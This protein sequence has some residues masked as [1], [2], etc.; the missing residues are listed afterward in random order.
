MA[1]KYYVEKKYILACLHPMPS[2]ERNLRPDVFAKSL[3]SVMFKCP[4]VFS[5]REIQ[6]LI[7]E[8]EVVDEI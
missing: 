6:V 7:L 2:S 1:L 8:N 4:Q 5:Y 3:T